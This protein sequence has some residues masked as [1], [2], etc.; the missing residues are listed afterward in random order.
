MK[1][2]EDIRTEADAMQVHTKLSNG[3]TTF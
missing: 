2:D 3:N 1:S